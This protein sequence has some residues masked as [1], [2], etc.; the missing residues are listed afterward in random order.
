MRIKIKRVI[1]AFII[2]F[3][4]FT[5]SIVLYIYLI[6]PGEKGPERHIVVDCANSSSAG[7]VTCTIA[8]ATSDI[9]FAKINISILKPDGMIVAMWLA[10]IRFTL[11]INENNSTLSPILSG[12]IIDNK[13][14]SFGVGDKI[15]LIPCDN[16]SLHDLEVKSYGDRTNDIATIP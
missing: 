9:D 7:N 13:D 10:P 15:H 11:G 16:L 8:A 6:K 1:L 12:K 4:V 14:G 3:V 2:A 5:F